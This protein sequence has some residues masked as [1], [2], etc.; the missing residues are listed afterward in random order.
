MNFGGVA[1]LTTAFASLYYG[2]KGFEGVL[3]VTNLLHCGF[4]KLMSALVR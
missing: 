4:E 3:V 2:H 1:V